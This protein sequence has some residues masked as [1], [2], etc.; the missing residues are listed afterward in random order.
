MDEHAAF[1]IPAACAAKALLPP[2]FPILLVTKTCTKPDT[3]SSVV[4][5][6]YQKAGNCRHRVTTMSPHADKL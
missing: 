3:V 1:A 5:L 4:T 6:A 2:D